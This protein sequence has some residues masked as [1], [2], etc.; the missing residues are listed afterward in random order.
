LPLEYQSE[1]FDF[2]SRSAK[3]WPILAKFSHF[4]QFV[5]K[6]DTKENPIGGRLMVPEHYKLSP[7]L[8]FFIRQSTFAICHAG[9]QRP[10]AELG[11]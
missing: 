11:V 10:P 3:T 1:I 6:L 7:N 9:N 2:F 5:N 4:F 8:N